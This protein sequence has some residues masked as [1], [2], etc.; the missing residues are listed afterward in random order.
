MSSFNKGSNNSWSV[1]FNKMPMSLEE[2]KSLPESSL[3]EPYYAVALL[4]P[5]LCLW[6]K[7]KEEAINMINFLRGP[8]ILS[9]YESQFI[10]ERLRGNEYIPMSYFKGATPENGY[11]PQKPFTVTV[12]SVPGSF[13]E[14]G[15][16][17]LYLQSGGADSPRPVKL[18]KKPSTGQWFLTDQMLLAQIREPVSEDPWA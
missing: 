9:N 12:S 15:Y 17:Q 18:R 14:E 13:A 16:A 10:S 11:E 3:N 7:N 2:I 8:G 4:I 6:P 5:T 1:V